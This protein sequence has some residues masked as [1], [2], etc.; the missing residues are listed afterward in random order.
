MI[1]YEN[2]TYL[3]TEEAANY[4]GKNITA[5]RQYFY[6]SKMSR[7]KLG[8]RLYFAIKD[9]DGVFADDRFKHFEKS[10]LSYDEVYTIDQLL[11]IFMTTKQYVYTFVSRRKIKR[12]KDN[13]NKTLYNRQ[14][15]DEYLD[16]VKN[17]TPD[18]AVND[19]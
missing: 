2:E 15:V 5:F 6:R 1:K 17:G 7:R 11:G 16:G 3:N 4:L 8:G 13:T 12:Y 18:E 10:G 9:L 19:L 14:Q